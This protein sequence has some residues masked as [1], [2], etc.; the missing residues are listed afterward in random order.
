MLLPYLNVHLITQRLWLTDDMNSFMPEYNSVSL[1][2]APEDPCSAWSHAL[3][4]L[5]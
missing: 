4:A 3:I 1:E 2:Y 5:S